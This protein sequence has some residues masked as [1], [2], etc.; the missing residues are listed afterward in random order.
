MLYFTTQV[1]DMIASFP[2][3]AAPSI[4][5]Y[6]ILGVARP[7]NKVRLVKQ[8]IKKWRQGDIWDA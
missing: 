8:V 2:T 3:I 7:G 5:Q 4:C 1:P 6:M